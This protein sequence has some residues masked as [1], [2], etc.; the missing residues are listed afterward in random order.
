[1][2]AAKIVSEVADVQRFPSEA[3]FARY[4]GLAP[5]PHWSGTANV[6]ER[7][8]RRGNRQLN[9]ALHRIAVTQIRKDSPGK[10]YFQRRVDE[11]DSRPR[12]LRCSNRRL[13]RV[14]YQRL[15]ADR[16]LRNQTSTA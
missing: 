3:T 6:H 13:S 5:V 16:G 11:G 10:T 14:V 4:V 7:P 2:T 15:Q 8:T 12:A 9:A 1:L